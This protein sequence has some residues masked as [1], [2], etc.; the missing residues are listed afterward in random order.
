MDILQWS[1]TQSYI[2]TGGGVLSSIMIPNEHYNDPEDLPHYFL[3][4]NN[5]HHI[6]N[7]FLLENR[8]SHIICGAW[9]RPI[10]SG[11]WMESSDYDT[12]AFNLQTPSIFIDL[13]FPVN[14]PIDTFK[15]SSSLSDFSIYNLQILSRQHCFGGYTLPENT[16][17]LPAV[18]FPTGPV[19][20]RFHVIDWNYHPSYPRPRPNRWWVDVKEDAMSFKEYSVA[21]DK[22]GVPVYYERW[23]RSPG[24]ANGRKYLAMRTKKRV[25]A[26]A[27][28][29]ATESTSHRSNSAIEEGGSGGRDGLLVVVGDHFACA[30]DRAAPFPDFPGSSGPGGPA[31]I[32]FAVAQIEQLGFASDEAMEW[33]RKV[34]AY[35]DLEGCYGRVRGVDGAG[36]ESEGMGSPSAPCDWRIRRSTHPWREGQ[37]LWTT[38]DFQHTPARLVWKDGTPTAMEQTNSDTWDASVMS[39]VTMHWREQEWEMLECSF[40]A[41][42]LSAL[43]PQP[44]HLSRL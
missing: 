41:A 9:S 13:R 38:A 20:T 19:F 5:S 2:L 18:G 1:N 23:Q 22:F 14:R 40:S 26:S 30:F 35:L 15:F 8:L 24:D 42:E 12:E 44:M 6:F 25:P 36:D 32:D 28:A 39:S 27:S 33:K 3:M 16:T 43:F 17:P 21:R 37:S 7:I 11:G 10:F 34:V 31:L 29:S 4:Q